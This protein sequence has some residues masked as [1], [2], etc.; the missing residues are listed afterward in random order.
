MVQAIGNPGQGGWA[1]IILDDGK[2][3]KLKEVKRYYK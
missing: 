2:K 3:L 1:A